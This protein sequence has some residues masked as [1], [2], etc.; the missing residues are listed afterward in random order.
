MFATFCVCWAAITLLAYVAV[1]RRARPASALDSNLRELREALRREP[2]P[3]SRRGSRTASSSCSCSSRSRSSR[4]SSPGSSA[5]PAE[6]AELAREAPRRWLSCSSGPALIAYGEAAVAYAGE[7]RGAGRA[8]AAS[9]SG[10]CGIGWLAQTALLIAQALDSD[11][12]PVGHLGGRAQPLR[13]ARRRRVPD[14]GLHAPLPAA[15][16]RRD[17][18]RG[19]CCSSLAWAGG[20]TAF[21]AGD[22]RLACSRCTSA[23]ML[24]ALRR[25]DARGRAWRRLYLWQERRL[26]RRDAQRA[27]RCACRRSTSL[28]RL[29]ARTVLGS[30]VAADARHRRRRSRSFERGDFDARDGGHARDLGALRAGPRRFATRRAGAAAASRCSSWPASRSSPIVLPLTH[31]AS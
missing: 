10:A 5:R 28:D 14:L 22:R 30:L 3:S 4:R 16:P 25:A 15:R 8:G 21:D 13:L 20:G 29:A 24:A 7:L 17:A 11:G 6:L 19:S 26:K 27:A 2:G 18:V 31:F 1:P 23:L 9:A 12:L